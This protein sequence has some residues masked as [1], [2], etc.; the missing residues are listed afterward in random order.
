[1]AIKKRH[2]LAK[3]KIKNGCHLH[4][5]SLHKLKKIKVVWDPE[6]HFC[7]C[8]PRPFL[9]IKEG[10]TLVYEVHVYLKTVSY[11]SHLVHIP[12]FALHIGSDA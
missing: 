12:F 4:V 10:D 9:N 7:L 8:Q 1:M 2:F 5:C 11:F 6:E 3:K